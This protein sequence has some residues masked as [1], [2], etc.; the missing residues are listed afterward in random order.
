MLNRGIIP[1]VIIFVL[2][3]LAAWLLY[4][5]WGSVAEGDYMG[6]QLGGAVAVFVVIFLLL[7]QTYTRFIR[8]PNVRLKLSFDNGSIPNSIDEKS[9]CTYQI[10]N[11]TNMKRS[12]PREV[13]LLKEGGALVFYT[14]SANQEDLIAVQLKDH[15]GAIWTSEYEGL[16]VRPLTLT[17][18]Q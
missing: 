12:V 9:R 14:D 13:V 3:L 17:K 6:F 7:R 5:V 2:S 4:A 10:Y 16:L 15:Q 18:G 8:V 1:M 11:R